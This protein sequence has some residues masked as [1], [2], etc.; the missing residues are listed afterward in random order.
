MV[1]CSINI[2]VIYSW[3]YEKSTWGRCTVT[4]MHQLERHQIITTNDSVVFPNLIVGHIWRTDTRTPVVV[5]RTIMSVVFQFWV[6]WVPK[7]GVVC[8]LWILFQVRHTEFLRARRDFFL[9]S[10]DN[11]ESRWPDETWCDWCKELEEDHG[12]S[13]GAG[14]ASRFRPCQWT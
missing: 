3:D 4:S 1:I 5:S 11:L 6:L 8:C 10:S 14:T 2:Q 13:H 12:P 7:L 9:V